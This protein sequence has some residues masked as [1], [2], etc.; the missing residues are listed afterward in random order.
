MN[1]YEFR[2]FW[3]LIVPT[4]LYRLLYFMPRLRLCAYR[5]GVRAYFQVI[6]F[7]MRD[8]RDLGKFKA[9]SFTLGKDGVESHVVLI[10]CNR[11]GA[12]VSH[13]FFA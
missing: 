3:I 5:G 4:Y 10:G 6:L 1:I 12:G 8:V 2:I 9:C 7:T 11:V 13:D